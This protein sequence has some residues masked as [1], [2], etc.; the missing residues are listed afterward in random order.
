LQPGAAVIGCVTGPRARS[1]RGRRPERE[2]ERACER[3]GWQL[4]EVVDDDHDGDAILER[5]ALARALERIAQGEARGLVV[6]DARP[7]SRSADF[8]KFVQWFR[9]ADAALVALDLGLDTSTP[10]GHRV[11]SA[12][13]TLNGW[14]GEWIASR[15]RQS[16]IDIRRGPNGRGRSAEE[17]AELL[18][19][20]TTLH[21]S[22]LEPQEIADQLN[23]ERVP[24]LFDTERWWPSSIQAALRYSRAGSRLAPA[25]RHAHEGRSAD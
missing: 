21:D 10:E 5:P 12:L 1:V 24:T 2:I 20:I 9:D 16:V 4:V 25:E 7:L 17:R 18:E 6:N 14:A 13:I 8:A 3:F 15:P 23:D 22:G 19:R 11:A